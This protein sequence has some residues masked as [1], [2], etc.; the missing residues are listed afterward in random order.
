[1]TARRSSWLMAVQ[2]AISSRVRPQPMQRPEAAS[3]S[4]TSTQGVSKGGFGSVVNAFYVGVEPSPD[5]RL[6][7]LPQVLARAPDAPETF[8][9][10]SGQRAGSARRGNLSMTRLRGKLTLTSV[11]RPGLL[12]SSKVP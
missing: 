4:Q 1:M 11:P 3:I 9:R 12:F 2:A 8:A 7:A 5:N 10:S 6:S